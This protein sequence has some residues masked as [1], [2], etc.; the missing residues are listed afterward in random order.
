MGPQPFGD[1]QK[2]A[3]PPF[4]GVRTTGRLQVVDGLLGQTPVLLP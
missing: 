2:H 1:G 4:A 3:P